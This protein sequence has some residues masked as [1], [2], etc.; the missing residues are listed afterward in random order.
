M[1]IF[2]I[3]SLAGGLAIFLFGMSVLGSGLEKASS[4]KLK[5][6]FENLTNNIFLSVLLGAGVTTLVQSSSATT[7]IVVGLVNAGILK[8][9]S[10]I[11]VIMG[12]NIGTTVTAQLLRLGDLENNTNV[13]VLLKFFKPST[14]APLIAVVGILI[15]MLSKKS[16][17]KTIGEI[18]L[19]FAVLFTG[20]LS[21]EHAVSGLRDNPAFAQVFQTLTNPILGVLAGALVTAIIQSSSASVAILQ[22]L[23]ST[24]AIT[25]ASAFPIIM[26]QNIGTCITPM[27]SS[28]GANKNAKRAAMI[29]LYFNIIGTVA[30]LILVYGLKALYN[31]PFWEHLINSLP[32]WTDNVNPSAIWSGTMNKSTIANF[33]TMFNVIVTLGFIPFAK[34]LEKLAL[35]T[36]KSSPDEEEVEETLLDERFFKSPSVAIQQSAK[37]VISMGKYAKINFSEVRMLFNNSKLDL[38][39]VERIKEN[40]RTLDLLEDKLSRY[41][42]QISSLELTEEESK[43]VTAQ[44]CILS[45]FERI[46]DYTINVLECAE[47]IFD[48]QISLSQHA[49]KELNL[50]CDALDEVI[51][52]A[53]NATIHDDVNIATQIEPLEEAID[54]IVET[55]KST[56]IK[57]FKTGKCGPD[58]S[59]IFLDVLTNMERISDHCSNIGV[60]LVIKASKDVELNRHQYIDNLH[61]GLSDEFTKNTERYSEKYNLKS[62]YN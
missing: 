22:T 4:G 30:F 6:V 44:L 34:Y 5:S 35:W 16:K 51:D 37:V 55:L 26:G 18:L 29:H 3:I 58:A 10:A 13:S 33:H 8:L 60:S 62:L 53:L 38:K 40:E 20:I 2:Q 12:A 39:A 15:Y 1:D 59:I 61:N 14:L 36:I 48:K 9:S 32:F 7:V 49:L 11:G 28:I 54:Q 27:M 19:G 46:G 17:Y 50:M 43:V 57:R 56:H 45:E 52:L 47:I 42:V 23:S 24:G 21:M 41:L 25:F 31:L